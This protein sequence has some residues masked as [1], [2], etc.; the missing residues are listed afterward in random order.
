MDFRFRSAIG[1]CSGSALGMLIGAV[2]GLAIAHGF[3][4]M[5]QWTPIEL[6]TA[7]LFLLGHAVTIGIWIIGAVIGG[8][9]G[10]IVGAAIGASLLASSENRPSPKAPPDDL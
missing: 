9:I 4:P 5:P 10:S 3:Y 8:V 2:A 6:F 1:G 7:L